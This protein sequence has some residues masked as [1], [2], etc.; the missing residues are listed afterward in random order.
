MPVPVLISRY[1]TENPEAMTKLDEQLGGVDPV[2]LNKGLC[3]ITN[4]VLISPREKGFY[5]TCFDVLKCANSHGEGVRSILGEIEHICV[6]TPE[7]RA[8]LD[9]NHPFFDSFLLPQLHPP[10]NGHKTLIRWSASLG[11]WVNIG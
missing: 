2:T 9:I 7:A 5:D 8:F 11:V 10:R 1:I 4:S 3:D 6:S